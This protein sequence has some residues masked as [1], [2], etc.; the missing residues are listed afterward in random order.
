[1]GMNMNSSFSKEY[2][3]YSITTG[4]YYLYHVM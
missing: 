3:E 2:I 1:M 4:K